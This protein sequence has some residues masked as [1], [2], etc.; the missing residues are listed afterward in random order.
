MCQYWLETPVSFS[1]RLSFLPEVNV[2]MEITLLIDC[3]FSQNGVFSSFWVLMMQ[4]MPD[5]LSDFGKG[6]LLWF[7]GIAW[8][9]WM[10]MHGCDLAE[11]DR[12][13][14]RVILVN[15]RGNELRVCYLPDFHVKSSAVN[16]ESCYT[17]FIKMASVYGYATEV[18]KWKN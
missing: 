10:F 14:N 15:W 8:S 1:L 16:A 2:T 17:S 11:F 13:K 5:G 3:K 4:M 6:A 18:Q 9:S 12:A 7:V